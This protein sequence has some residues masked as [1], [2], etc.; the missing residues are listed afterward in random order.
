[1]SRFL[2]RLAAATLVLAT[3]SCDDNDPEKISVS[4][5]EPLPVVTPTAALLSAEVKVKGSTV[6]VAYDRERTRLLGEL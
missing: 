6:C 4:P 1:M 2:V 5:T 3:M